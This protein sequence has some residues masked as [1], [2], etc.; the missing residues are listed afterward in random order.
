MSGPAPAVAALRVAV[1]R[2]LADLPGD[3]GIGVALSG[4]PDSLAL[5]AAAAFERPGRVT[6]LVVDQHWYDGSAHACATAAERVRDVGAH[7]VVLDGP[8]P[9][10][11]AAARDA[12]YA[13]LAAAAEEYDLATVLVGHTADDQAETVLLALLRGSGARSLA[14]M[15]A[16]RGLFRRPLLEV[17]RETTRAACAAQGLAPLHDPANDDRSFARTRVRELA[18]TLG[19]DVTANL[20]RSARLLRADADLLDA[21]AADADVDHRDGGLDAGKLAAL[22]AALRTRV[23]HRLAPGLAAAHVDAL[24]SLVTDWH[25]QG[26]V[27][28]PGGV[29]VVRASDR[30]WL[31]GRASDEPERDD[32]CGG[33]ARRGD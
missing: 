23:L 30:I 3:A 11:E 21:L 12:R 17:T 9:R 28:L 27:G 7:A 5:A 14:G 2:C 19:R 4:G 6:A 33:D 13:A 1:R 29:R 26:P 8:A 15:P 18:A 25:G 10:R 31:D 24:D 16:A 32:P 20:V 22:P